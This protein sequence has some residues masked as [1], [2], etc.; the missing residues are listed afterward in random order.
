MKE[1]KVNVRVCFF[2]P[3]FEI[4]G[5][6]VSYMK[7]CNNLVKKIQNIELVYCKDIGTLRK[8]FDSRVNMI[9]LNK[10]RIVTVILALKQYYE[11]SKPDIFITPMFMLGNAAIIAR[12]LSSH[13]PKIII[14]ARSTFSEVLKSFDTRFKYMSLYLLSKIL[15]PLADKIISVSNGVRN[16]LSRTL[17]INLS[18]ISTI[19]NPVIDNHHIKANLQPPNHPW[20]KN[21]SKN[22]KI[23]I[24]IGRLAEEKSFDV[25][26]DVFSRIKDQEDAKLLIIGEGMLKSYLIKLI[27][28]LE[29]NEKVQILDFQTNYLSF[30]AFADIFVLNSKFE[31]LPGIL[32]EALALD[33]R[34][35][36]SDCDHGPKE[37][38]LNGKHGI[39]FPVGDKDAL[40]EAMEFSL[41]EKNYK[42]SFKPF[43]S[44]FTVSLSTQLYLKEINKLISGKS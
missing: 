43:D 19:Y 15:F 41:K 12:I 8:D 40:L 11:T 16:D 36:S 34:V 44:N 20:F 30:L 14:G 33:C 23:I 25:V 28:D 32:I 29:L 22:C 6:E 27:D 35:I 3:N 13:K 21:K 4:G 9:C 2:V 5:I 42:N 24:C 1:H 39:L 7:L 17:N 31:G 38:L 18:K 37:I 26:I 10:T